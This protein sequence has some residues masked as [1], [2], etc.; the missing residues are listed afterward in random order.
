MRVF[1]LFIL[2]LLIGCSAGEETPVFTMVGEWEL[3]RSIDSETQEVITGDD[4]WA[5]E[6]Y[7]FNSDSTFQKQRIAGGVMSEA[8]GGYIESGAGSSSDFERNITLTFETGLEII[9]SCTP[10]EGIELLRVFDN[11]SMTNT[12]SACDGP[13]MYYERR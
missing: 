13:E 11:G 6:T 3:V 1:C 8:T 5:R 9:G 12:W 10:S 4:M 7:V 2:V